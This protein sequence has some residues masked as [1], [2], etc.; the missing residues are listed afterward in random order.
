MPVKAE[1]DHP[2]NEDEGEP[3]TSFEK[4]GVVEVSHHSRSMNPGARSRWLSA[5]PDFE[6]RFAPHSTDSTSTRR[7]AVVH[8]QH[9]IVLSTDQAATVTHQIPQV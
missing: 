1:S 8:G 2:F 3:G 6:R 9:D 7:N 4:L 5:M